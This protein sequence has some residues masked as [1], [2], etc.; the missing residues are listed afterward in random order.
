MKLH[1]YYNHIDEIWEDFEKCKNEE[2][3]QLVI[4]NIPHK[5]GD[6]YYEILEDKKTFKIT[7]DYEEWGDFQT[8]TVEFDFL[9]F[10][11][12]Y[13][14]KIQNIEVKTLFNGWRKVS[15]EQAKNCIKNFMSG[16]STKSEQEKID[17]INTKKLKGITVNEVLKYEKQQDMVF[18]R[19]LALW[20]DGIDFAKDRIKT[21]YD[22]QKDSKDIKY[23]TLK[24]VGEKHSKRM[25]NLMFELG[26]GEW[27]FRDYEK[28]DEM[29]QQIIE[30]LQEDNGIDEILKKMEITKEV[31]FEQIK[32][33]VLE[34]EINDCINNKENY[35]EFIKEKLDEYLQGGWLKQNEFDFLN[36]NL[37][38][39]S[40][41]CFVEL[42][43]YMSL[44]EEFDMLDKNIRIMLE[45]ISE[46]IEDEEERG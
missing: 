20:Q 44:E 5:F 45:E 19:N 10:Q 33:N 37:F 42:K 8:N 34:N 41:K 29:Q 16:I 12:T 31:L 11:E 15:Y 32:G 28:L 4:D 25:A 6:F 17:Y 3:I 38:K 7:N 2:D 24:E 46:N 14:K 21:F 35:D 18:K 39:L 27:V 36:S 40:E 22:K 30:V 13:M 26:Y 1:S 9:G 43:D 23:I